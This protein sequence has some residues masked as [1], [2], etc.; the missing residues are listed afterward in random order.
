MTKKRKEEEMSKP[1]A[2]SPDEYRTADLPVAALLV[3]LEVPLLAVRSDGRRALFIFPRSAEATACRFW[4]PGE[5]SV[6]A[7]RFYMSLRE[8]RGMAR[9]AL[10]Y[11]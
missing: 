8:L 3:T 2:L 7:R 9:G 10:Q 6:S 5:D 11:D 1:I 4:Q